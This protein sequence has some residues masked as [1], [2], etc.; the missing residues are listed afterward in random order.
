MGQIQASNTTLT[1]KCRFCDAGKR[2]KNAAVDCEICASGKYIERTDVEPKSCKDCPSGRH[3]LDNGETAEEHNEA[4][5]CKPCEKGKSAVDAKSSCM[6]C[7]TGQYQ[8]LDE[9]TENNC[10]TCLNGQQFTTAIKTCES[11]PVGKY[12]NGT[13]LSALVATC[14]FCKIG[15]AFVAASEPCV[16]CHTGQYQDQINIPSVSCKSC[17]AGQASL[18]REKACNICDVTTLEFQELEIAEVYACQT[19]VPGRIYVDIKT[20]CVVCK[21]GFAALSVTSTECNACA[22]GRYQE[23]EKSGKDRCSG[24]SNLICFL[25]NNLS[26]FLL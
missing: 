14:K 15:Q 9:A 2:F 21:P 12:Q 7:A 18:D 22:E 11:C 25:K 13:S 8:E 3:I 19:C 16:N 20:A 6:A 24:E 10:K 26:F 1:A 17:V 23:M 4:T 5:D